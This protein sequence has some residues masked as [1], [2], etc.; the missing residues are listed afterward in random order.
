MIDTIIEGIIRILLFLVC[1]IIAAVIIAAILS[2]I[3]LLCGN[4]LFHWWLVP[5]WIIALM[6]TAWLLGE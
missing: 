3:E 1:L 6:F 4:I 5:L 2:V